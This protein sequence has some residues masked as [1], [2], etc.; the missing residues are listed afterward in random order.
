MKATGQV[1]SNEFEAI[2]AI[3]EEFAKEIESLLLYLEKN[4]ERSTLCSKLIIL[5]KDYFHIHS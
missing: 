3:R 5:M 4:E 1:I 2:E